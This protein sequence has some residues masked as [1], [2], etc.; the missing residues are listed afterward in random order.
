MQAE[1]RASRMISGHGLHSNQRPA[2]PQDRN[3]IGDWATVNLI[4]RFVAG[5]GLI[6]DMLAVWYVVYVVRLI[7]R[8]R[9]LPH[10]QV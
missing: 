4:F 6:L 9:A 8:C 5:V 7:F 2:N 1:S 3:V 10:P